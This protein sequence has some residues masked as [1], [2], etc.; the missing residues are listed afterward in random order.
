MAR[1]LVLF[2]TAALDATTEIDDVGRFVAVGHEFDPGKLVINTITSITAISAAR[3]N[4]VGMVAKIGR[5][6]E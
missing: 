6:S 3:L 4:R 2:A 1:V 5:R